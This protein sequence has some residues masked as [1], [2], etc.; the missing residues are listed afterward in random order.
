MLRNIFRYFCGLTL[1]ILGGVG[2]VSCSDDNNGLEI[3]QDQ[4]AESGYITLSLKCVEGTR[5]PEDKQYT[6]DGVT[7]LNENLIKSV[8]ICLW[9][10]GGD[11]PDDTAKPD[12]VQTFTNVDQNNTATFRIP[13]TLALKH[14]L[15]ET[16]GA[17]CHAFAAVNV[18]PPA[19]EFTI[20]D[21]RNMA[22]ES[23]F[24]S[25][26]TQASF[27]MDGDCVVSYNP[28]E[29]SAKG[30]MEL[31]R[32][33]SKITLAL[34]V[35]E[36]VEQNAIVDGALVKS[37][38]QPDTDH[39][40]V[41][42]KGGL[43]ESTLDPD[44][45]AKP[46]KDYFFDTS[47]ER[48][49]TFVENKGGADNAPDNG[50][51]PPKVTDNNNT[52]RTYP[53]IQDCPF[54]TYPH[55]WTDDPKDYAATFMILA[56]PW[57]QVEKKGDKYEQKPGSTWRT[58]YYQVPVIA[59]NSELLQ[60]VRNVSYHVYL[61]VGL[62]GSFEPD[63][64][65]ELDE[66]AYSAAEWGNVDIDVSIPDV[67]YL[68]VDQNDYT[69]NNET[70][71]N[72][73]FYTSHE[74]I[75]TD[76]TMTFYRY[77]FSDAGEERAVTVSLQQ[78]EESANRAGKPV[79]TATFNNQTKELEVYHDLV[80]YEARDDNNQLVSFTNG[81]GPGVS[82]SD[83][84]RKPKTEAQWKSLVLDK[85]KYFQK[86]SPEDNEYSRVEFKITLQH[87]DIY[88]DGKKPGH[89]P[90][91]NFEEVINITQYPG[92]YITTVPNYHGGDN[93]TS[94]DDFTGR[95]GNAFINTNNSSLGGNDNRPSKGI[96][97]GWTT[98]IGLDSDNFNFNPNM[99][100]V[101][102]TTL[103][104]NTDYII[105]DPRSN[106][107][108]NYLESSNHNYDPTPL[109][110]RSPDDNNFY[111]T[112]K[113]N[114]ETTNG[115]SIASQEAYVRA[116]ITN[117]VNS[118]LATDKE[119]RRTWNGTTYTWYYWAIS[120]PS[121]ENKR[122]QD[123]VILQNSSGSVNASGFA[124]AKAIYPN[125][126]TRSL[127]YYYPTHEDNAHKW[128]IAPKFRI[129]SSYAGTTWILNRELARRR[130]A[131][132]QEM[133]YAAGRW[134]L[135]TFGEVKFIMELAAAYKIPR[136]FGTYSATW[137][138]W[139]AQGLVCVPAKKSNSRSVTLPGDTEFEY[140]YR[141]WGAR[142]CHRARFVYD[143]WY[144]GEADLPHTGTI[145][146]DNCVYSY[147]WGDKQF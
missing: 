34:S 30:N 131:S 109:L 38:W 120:D 90:T 73:P 107:I 128:M 121:S 82:A 69:V 112:Y 130:A 116:L 78:N 75:V 87:K 119:D 125:E 46:A 14:K 85:I 53:F 22:I 35:D 105:G 110:G 28:V 43:A 132:Y 25:R 96:P 1:S 140:P 67:R 117:G 21:L 54:Y 45:K 66:L 62:L 70:S 92:M 146:S 44:L 60:L 145:G 102:V 47:D 84:S 68:V 76:A 141:I 122:W 59:E 36:I 18:T 3:P 64:P 41:W 115:Y 124:N 147:T 8:T 138:Y 5:A 57:R 55:R 134:R 77:N 91:K 13:L 10:K 103:P 58:C 99:Y 26:R 139:C 51:N 33:A 6:E 136:L 94:F 133:G 11:K 83:Q 29:K 17:E 137:W 93:V 129:C 123:F 95:Q 106:Y 65:L 56:I 142:D 97:L 7:S 114:G 113:K 42:L 98:S 27:A 50:N 81:D 104:E 118:S 135:P 23:E 37:E 111:G 49:Y 12:Y 24:P 2:F 88:D 15:F 71:I 100:L 48:V 16:S 31:Q 101:T 32:S 89:T 143:E 127:S 79:F 63:V 72:I 86:V 9:A 52:T 4:I 108:N 144:W 74:T 39:M 126:N 20:A 61:H 19:G 40:R 80:M